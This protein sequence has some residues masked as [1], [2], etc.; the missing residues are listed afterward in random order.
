MNFFNKHEHETAIKRL[1]S[2]VI[3]QKKHTRSG[4]VEALL[5]VT[6]KSW[7]KYII[8][9]KSDFNTISGI[10]RRLIE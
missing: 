2:N 5:D 6:Q 8:I 7:V 3:K 9:F 10:F 1:F 4:S